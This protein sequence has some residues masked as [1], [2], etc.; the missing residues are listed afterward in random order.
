MPISPENDPFTR[1]PAQA[2][3]QKALK[4]CR[5]VYRGPLHIRE[6]GPEYLPRF[7]REPEEKYQS[8][9]QQSVLYDWYARTVRGLTGM[10]FREPP[11]LA[12]DLPPEITAAWENIDL[13]GNHGRVFWHERHLDGEIDGHFLVFVD[14]SSKLRRPYTVGITKGQVLDALVESV[15]GVPTLVHFRYLMPPR[16]RRK[17]RYGYE[18]LEAVREY[19]LRIGRGGTTYVEWIE[20]TRR[21]DGDKAKGE[22]ESTPPARME[23]DEIPLVAGYHGHRAGPFVTEPG[24]LAL[25][26][27]NVKHYQLVSDNDNVLHLCSVPQ[28]AVIGQD[29]TTRSKSG[30][31]GPHTGW[32]LPMGAQIMYAEPEGNGLEAAERRITKSEQRMALL[33]LSML[34]S[35]SRSAETATSK[36]IDKSES[37]SQLALHAS[38]T[39]DAMEEVLRLM[40][41]W[42]DTPLPKRTQGRWVSVE[43]DFENLPLEAPVIQAF[44]ALISKGLPWRPVLEMMAQRG[45]LPKNTDLDALEL[46]ILAAGAAR[47][48][49]DRLEQVQD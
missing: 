7:P 25:A 45:R 35:E 37:D 36:R 14:M 31:V 12:E 11:A 3:Q 16:M 1:S 44:A 22:V 5:D 38:A 43:T 26:I 10:V 20:H 34:H 28:F 47:A 6:Q 13:L 33:G 32:D 41:K 2:E 27:E 46:E 40:G 9:L 15:E 48:D 30:Q 39:N 29:D 21:K 24:H 8:R 4:I 49:I 23:I 42:L 19:N 17:G 18:A